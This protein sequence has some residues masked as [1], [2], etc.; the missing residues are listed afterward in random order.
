MHATAGATGSAGSTGGDHASG[1]AGAAGAVGTAGTGGQGGGGS[2][3]AGT[4]GGRGGGASGGVAGAVGG[5]GG[6]ASGGVA[7]AV[8]G[9]G[10]SASGT[11]GRGGA[12]ATTNIG[13][14]SVNQTF[15]GTS[16]SPS[17]TA[18]FVKWTRKVEC[19]PTTTTGN[20]QF[21][22]CPSY[23]NQVPI[24]TWLDAG[25]VTVTGFARDFVMHIL[26]GSYGTESMDA[27]WTASRPLTVQVAGSANVP[28]ATLDVVAPN[29]IVLTAPVAA[30]GA[31]LKISTAANLV[32][33]W[34]GGVEGTVTAVA[35][36]N[37]QGTE[38]FL[39]YCS[40][41]AA[42][43]SLTMPAALLAKLGSK[44]TFAAYVDNVT[45]KQ[46]DDWTMRFQVSSRTDRI[47]VT[48][49]K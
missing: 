42:S 29:P 11:A 36:Y 33:T 44:G 4:V 3:V 10:G 26:G 47:D 39:V 38:D 19:K 24:S 32:V 31:G 12:D 37:N 7:G 8:G 17:L 2:G 45:T 21:Y 49:T 28:A 34:T 48:Y 30:G 22:D 25:D 15:P 35:E 14:I 41:P 13:T 18:S 40:A 20:C 46:V 16:T 6:N 5:R 9:R 1:G 23:T 27:A 43:G